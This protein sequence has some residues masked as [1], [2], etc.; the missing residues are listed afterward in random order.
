MTKLTRYTNFEAL[1]SDFQ[2]SKE[3]SVKDNE[4]PSEFEAFV[5]RMKR[6]LA[7]K[8]KSKTANGKQFS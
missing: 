7:F 5:N 4:Q 3:A 6:E 8:K 1:K 2:S